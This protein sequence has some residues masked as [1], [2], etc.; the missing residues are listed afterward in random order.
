MLADKLSAIYSRKR[1]R[2]T[3]DIYDFYILTNNFDVSM[4][5]LRKYV[6]LR[7]TIEWDKDP[8]REDVLIQYSG[9]YDKLKV[10]SI[11]GKY[12]EK[13]RFSD[14]IGRVQVI[15]NEFNSDCKWSHTDRSFIKE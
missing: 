4:K 3:K 12:I 10:Y 11:N 5:L 8:F 9:V 6:E 14:V 13:P 1:F 2:R 7:G 15:V